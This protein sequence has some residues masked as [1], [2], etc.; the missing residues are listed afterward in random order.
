[1]D[2]ANVG[3]VFDWTHCCKWKTCGTVTSNRW[4]QSSTLE[5]KF[6]FC[7]LSTAVANEIPSFDPFF[8]YWI[9]C[10]FLWFSNA[11]TKRL[12]EFRWRHSHEST[13][14][15]FSLFIFNLVYGLGLV[16]LFIALGS[17]MHNQM[18]NCKPTNR[19]CPLNSA[20]PTPVNHRHTLLLY[21]FFIVFKINYYT[22]RSLEIVI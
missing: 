5:F 13:F 11:I 3:T 6:Q 4:W 21:H 19:L 9:F 20:I 17:V 10:I 1:M 2:S 7:C 12:Q 22:S 14:S 15:S 18:H 8:F 16:C